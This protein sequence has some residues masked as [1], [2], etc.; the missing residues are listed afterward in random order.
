MRY[1]SYDNIGYFPYGAI[2]LRA[3]LSRVDGRGVTTT[4]SYTDAE[5]L[6]TNIHYTLPASP[7]STLTSLADTSF[8]Y[9]SYDRRSGM[10]D[11]TGSFVYKYDDDDEVLGVQTSYSA[12]SSATNPTTSMTYAYWPGGGRETMAYGYYPLSSIG[13][14]VGT[15]SYAYDSDGRPSSITNPF[16]EA[17]SWTYQAN[18]WLASQ[19]LDNASAAVV[20]QATYV[21]DAK[22]QM[23]DLKNVDGSSNVLSEFGSTGGSPMVYDGIGDRT[24]MAVNIP[25]STLYSGSTSYTYD[26]ISGTGTRSQ[27]TQESST[28]DSSYTNNFAYDGGSYTASTGAGNPTTMR[29]ASNTFNSDNQNTAN[30]YDG[31]GNPTTYSGNT[32]GFDPENRMTFYSVSGTPVQTNT[33]D[34]NDHRASIQNNGGSTQYNI[35]DADDPVLVLDNSGTVTSVTTYGLDGV[36][37]THASSATGFYTWDPQGSLCQKLDSTSTVTY[38]REYDAFGNVQRTDSDTDDHASFGGQYGYWFDSV[39]GLCQLGHRFYDPA[40]GRFVTRDPSGYTGGINLYTYCRNRPLDFFDP[41]GLWNNGDTGGAVGG[42]VGGWGGAVFWGSV[43]AE[44]GT[45]LFPGVGTIVGGLIGGVLGGAA[46]G[47]FGGFLGTFIGLGPRFGPYSQIGSDY[48]CGYTPAE[49]AQMQNNA[50]GGA[51]GGG[52]GGL[53]GGFGGGYTWF[54]GRVA[55]AAE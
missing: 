24:S 1:A 29:G 19:T 4:Y 44:A 49:F 41:S 20:T 34:G 40:A 8:T 9:D 32:L 16:S 48:G 25:A 21:Y 55:A 39:T 31:S 5:S 46:G 37:S 38:T 3:V 12:L 53:L 11:A 35:F 42:A 17:S 26:S 52:I 22:G 30:S 45:L 2:A 50:I 23:T 10:T 28:R 7:P 14:A 33:Y 51:I 43:G 18:G 13:T 6:L 54:F 27:L 47:A 36:V 15:F